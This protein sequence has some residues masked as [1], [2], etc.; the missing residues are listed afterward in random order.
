MTMKTVYITIDPPNIKDFF[1][2]ISGSFQI[3]I[4][5]NNKPVMRTP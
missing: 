2:Y 3:K 4:I 5:I 1:I